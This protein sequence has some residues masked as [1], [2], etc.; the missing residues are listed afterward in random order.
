MPDSDEQQSQGFNLDRVLGI[1]RRRHLPFLIAL[2]VGWIAVWGASWVLPPRYK[3]STLIM[4]EEPTMPQD[5]VEPNVSDDLQTRVQNIKTQLLSKTRLLIIINR[6]HLYGGAQDPATA[7]GSVDRMRKDIDVDLVRDPQKLSVTAF[8]ISYTSADPN[9]A[10]QVTRELTDVFISE[11]NKVRQQESEGTTS[12]FEKQ[13]ED[14]RQSLADQEAKVRQF[15][16]GHEGDLPTQQGSNLEILS[17]LQSQ[18]Q[19]EA[20]S[21]NTAKQQRVYLQALMEQQKSAL[22]K[23]RPVN[24]T[25]AAY[26]TPTDLPTVDDQ[27]GRLQSQL[28]DL[29]SH[30][31]EQYPDV[32]RLKHQIARLEAVRE[33]IIA[34][35]KAR[36]KDPKPSVASSANIDDLDPSVS[37]PLQQTQSQLQANEVEITNRENAISSL[38]ARINDYQ[39]RLNAEPST[40]QQLADLNRGYDQSKQYYDELLKKKDDSVMATSMEQMQAGERF[41]MLDP[42]NLPMAPD[43]PNRLKFCGMGVGVGLMLG[44]ALAGG[45]EFMDDRMHNGKEIKALLP[46]AVISEIPEVVTVLDKKKAKRRVTLGWALTAFVAVVIVSGSVFSFLHS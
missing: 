35:A 15:E 11:N 23:A 12:F 28:D 14:A 41:I 43:F 39:G 5:Y 29:S 34:A 40:E 9:I 3:S 26:S 31:T 46:V 38:K 19:S 16:G 44:L 17:G 7:D 33:N 8:Q 10:Q 42:P 24:G 13:L 30:Y 32:V 4:V 25:G 37:A 18:L 6:L 21:L 1:A 2:L 22:S 36:S 45:L 20:D 27:L